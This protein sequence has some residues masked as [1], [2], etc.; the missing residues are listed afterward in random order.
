MQQ[1]RPATPI[2]EF[3][4][5]LRTE[6]VGGV[7]L[8]GATVVA[9]VWA[10]SPWAP[11]YEAMRDTVVGPAAL[12]LDLTLAHWATDGLLALFFFT[13][14]LELKRELVIGELSTK[15]QAL[16]PVAAALGGMIVPAGLALLVGRG[17]PGMEQAWAIPVATDIAFALGVLAVAGSALP[18]SARVFLLGL[19]VADDL[20]GIIV[21][22]VLFSSGLHALWLGAVVLAGLA[23]WWLQRRRVRAWW[24]YVPLGLF[25]W[26]AM[27][28][29]GVHATISGVLLGLLTRVRPDPDEE[30]APALRLEHRLQPWSAGLC[31]PV[32]ALFAAGVPV[33]PEALRSVLIEPVALGV[34]VGLLVG[35]VVGIFGSCWLVI[36]F[37]PASRPRGLSWRDLAAVSM[38]GG[39]GFTVSLLIAELSLEDQPALLATVKAGVLLASAAASVI[40]AAMLIRRGRVRARENGNGEEA[41]GP[42]AAS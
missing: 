3:A 6:T 16:L 35:K 8:L 30:F 28:E 29:A 9:L 21:I 1:R 36:R 7:V 14:G 40:G 22:A 41:G 4:R 5:Y 13:V 18:V 32:F 10:N 31:V 37:T 15:S 33:G 2:S 25:T 39:V 38:L 23:Y 17:A 42:A 19:A 34:V 20:G 26:F 12:H 11:F 27:H 24:I